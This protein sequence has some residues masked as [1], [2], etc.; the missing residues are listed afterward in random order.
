LISVIRGLTNQNEEGKEM[1]INQ[2][3]TASKENISAALEIE[4]TIT[5]SKQYIIRKVLH[6]LEERIGKPKLM[7]RFDYEQETALINNFYKGSKLTCPGISYFYKNENGLD[8]W[9]RIEIGWYLYAGLCIS[10]DKTLTKKKQKELEEKYPDF[11]Y[12][13]DTDSYWLSW[14]NIPSDVEPFIDYK[15]AHDG[16]ADLYDPAYFNEYISNC[17]TRINELWK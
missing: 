9:F 7:N 1:E 11:E 12:D 13:E 2:L 10:L 6:T 3:L 4:K 14:S 16:F 8:I 17:I 5:E 15:H